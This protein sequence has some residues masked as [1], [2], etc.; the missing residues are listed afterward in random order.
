MLDIS[1]SLAGLI[2]LAPVLAV[3]AVL[4]K[5]QD[6]G[7]VLYRQ[8]RVGRNGHRFNIVKFRTMSEDAEEYLGPVWS[9]PRDPR[10]TRLGTLLRRSGL[11]ELPQLW[12]VL[13]GDMSIVGPRPER[14]EFVGQ[15]RQELAMYDYRHQVQAG[16]TGYAQVHGWRGS[17][18]L[19]QR[20]C[21]DLY[22]IRN[23]T[24]ALDLKILVLT[25]LHGWSERTRSGIPGTTTI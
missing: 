22:Y 7:S 25:L 4:I 8:V 11:D 19:E 20:L 14:P 13:R 1:L 10:C 17:T 3:I 9:V 23:W 12:N 16:I 21:H 18:S 2:L 6:N 24:L 5:L 15:F